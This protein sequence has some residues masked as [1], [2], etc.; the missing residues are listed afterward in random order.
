MTTDY[1]SLTP[2]D[3]EKS[4]RNYIAYCISSK[5]ENYDDEE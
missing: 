1:S 4:V 5:S 2:N 3:F